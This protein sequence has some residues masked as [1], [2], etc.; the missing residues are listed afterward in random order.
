[1]GRDKGA[2]RDDHLAVGE[3]FALDAL[4]SRYV[5]PTARPFA[6]SI[7]RTGALRRTV[8]FG[9]PASGARKA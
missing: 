1:L 3:G 8:R 4:A 7:R 2:R 5:T 9:S 6:S